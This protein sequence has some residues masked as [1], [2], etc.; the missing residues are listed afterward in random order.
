MITYEEMSDTLKRR[1]QLWKGHRDTFLFRNR[2]EE[3]MYYH[4]VDGTGTAFTQD[5]LTKIATGSNIP[6]TINYLHPIVNQKLAILTQTK[7]SFKAVSLDSRGKQ[8]AYAI[9]K[10]VKSVMYSS[11]AVGEEEEAIKNMLLSG[12]GINIIEELDYY[13]FG[14]FNIEYSSIHPSMVILDI[15]AKKRSL[16]DME[17]YFIEKEITIETAKQKYTPI[18]DA[19][20]A[21]RIENEES[22][23]TFESFANSVD[24]YSRGQG[25]I[26]EDMYSSKIVVTEYFSKKFTTMYFIEDPDTSDIIRIFA[27]NLE[28][29]QQFVLGGAL[30]A[31]N[32]MF[33]KR[34]LFWGDYKVAEEI[35]SL[36]DFPIKVK[37]FEWGGRPYK[38]YGMPHF[39][40]GMQEAFDKAIQ[41][42]LINGML[43]NNAGYISPQGG[44]SPEQKTFWE[45]IGNKPGVVKEF[46]PTIIDGQ[47]LKPEREQIQGIS[48][49]YPTIMEMM[50]SGMEY[51]SGINPIVQ[52]NAQEAKVDVFASLQQ[53]QNAAM[54]RIQL[55]MSHINLANEQMGNIVIDY[56]LANLNTEQSY[57]FFDENNNLNEVEIT[58]ELAKT[59]K[60]GRYLILSIASEAMPTQKMA[61]ATELMKI[62]QTTPDP[63]DRNIYIQKAFELSDIRAFDDVQETIDVKNK[64]QSQLQQ[65]QEEIERMQ[66]LNK[67]YE[68]KALNA[69]YQVKLY[70]KLAGAESNITTAE[71]ESKKQI[72]ID[73]LK[74]QLKEKK[75]AD[76]KNES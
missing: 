23:L 17:G 55:A 26:I 52:G 49:F 7:P 33:V 41:T 34:E 38:C 70:Q 9:D 42:M 2:K 1:K 51:S 29:E 69:E 62:S 74:E 6:V 31:E 20:N 63:M 60:L 36:K 43:V 65:M 56:L 72:E 53:Y 73:K 24:S 22:I 58:K 14:R 68:N 30:D 28:E 16:S 61:M 59:F 50:K 10:M 76:S 32:G 48:N 71:A 40:L 37:F 5:Q 15:N 4:D 8:F 47:L 11:Q 39:L 27:E 12:M 57:A 18:L 46:V 66:E 19:I 67:Q 3:E 64:L 45:T 21:K 44:I 54:Q 35:K 75:N 13:Q 25:S